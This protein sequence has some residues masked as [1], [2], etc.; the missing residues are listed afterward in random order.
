MSEPVV[1]CE[2]GAKMGR[3]S[4]ILKVNQKFVFIVP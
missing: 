2:G 3:N 4:W 1:K